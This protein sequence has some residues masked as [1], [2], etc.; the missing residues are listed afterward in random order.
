MACGAGAAL[1]CPEVKEKIL[2]PVLAG[3]DREEMAV[4]AM[5]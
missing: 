1:E 3:P 2:R 5:E 4:L